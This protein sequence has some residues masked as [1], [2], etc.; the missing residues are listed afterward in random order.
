MAEIK[1]LV[2]LIEAILM[3]SNTNI[4]LTLR[5]IIRQGKLL[6]KSQEREVETNFSS[7]VRLQAAVKQKSGTFEEN[8]LGKK[9]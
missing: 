2:K 7:N 8:L 5:L 9:F 4:L 6:G 1:F 3:I